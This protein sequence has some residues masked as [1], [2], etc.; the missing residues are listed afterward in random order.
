MKKGMLPISFCCQQLFFNEV[1]DSSQR[2]QELDD[3]ILLRAFQLFKLLDDMAGLATMPGDS[4]E[5]R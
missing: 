3:G 1:M 2:L 4:V 5:K